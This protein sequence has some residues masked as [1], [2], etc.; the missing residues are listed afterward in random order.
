MRT[1]NQSLK[2]LKI[3]LLSINKNVLFIKPGAM[4]TFEIIFAARGFPKRARN[5]RTHT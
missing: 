3:T 5:V 4:T 2:I 1:M